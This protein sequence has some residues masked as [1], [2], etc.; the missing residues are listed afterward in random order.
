MKKSIKLLRQERL[1]DILEKDPFVTDDSLSKQLNVSI[2]TIRLDRMVLGIP[3]LRKRIKDVAKNNY[4]RV[5]TISESEIVGELVDLELND[6]AISILDTD[7]TMVFKKTQI[8]KG[9]YIFAMAESLALAV[10]D[11][12]VAIT[13]IANLKYKIPVKAGEKLVAKAKVTQIKEIEYYVHI[14]ISVQDEQVFRSKFIMKA[15]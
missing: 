13:G 11:A 7:G 6:R 8:V 14:F 10:I 1:I 5:K 2:Q 4:D 9:H 3:E 15:V 12:D